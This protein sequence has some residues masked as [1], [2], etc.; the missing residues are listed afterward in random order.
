MQAATLI[1][2]YRLEPHPEG[3]YY[4]ETW[5]S[6]TVIAREAL[7]EGFSGPRYCSTAILFL[8]E[9]RDVSRLHRIRSDEIWHFY[10]GGPLRLAMIFPN[11]TSKEIVL[12]QDIEAGQYVQYVVPAGVWFGAKPC[13]GTGFSFVGCTVSPGF[14]FADFELGEKTRLLQAFPQAHATIG[15]FCP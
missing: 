1:A 4:R 12:G 13:A 14:D 5:R 8:L 3:G 6:D 10:G 15:E 2:H 9:N 7:P 11:G